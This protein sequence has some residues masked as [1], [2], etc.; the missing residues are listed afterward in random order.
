ML[1]R[2]CDEQRGRRPKYSGAAIQFCLSIN[3]LFNLP[4]RQGLS[5]AQGLFDLSELNCRAGD[6]AERR[7]LRV[8]SNN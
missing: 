1:V 2:K 4:L 8:T 7:I 5:M 6:H 3:N